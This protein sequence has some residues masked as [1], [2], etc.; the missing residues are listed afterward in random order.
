MKKFTI[1]IP[2]RERCDVLYS[3]IRTAISQNYD[4]LEILISDNYSSDN[5]KDVVHSFNDPRVKYVNTGKRLSMSHNWEFALSH[6]DSGWITFIGDDDGILPGAIEKVSNIIKETKV[7]AVRSNGCTYLWPSLTGKEYGWLSVSTKKGYEIRK[8]DIYY[9]K[10]LKGMLPYTELPVLYNG[11]FVD[12]EVIKKAIGN[13]GY[14]YRSCIPDVYSAIIISEMI[15]EYIYCYEP[16]AINGASKHSN[17][18]SAFHKKGLYDEN[19]TPAKMFINEPN[20][21]LHR[22]IAVIA[23]GLYPLSL[24]AIVYESYLQ[25]RSIISKNIPFVTHM[26]QLKIILLNAGID[27][28]HDVEV[29]GKLFADTHGLEYDKAE[30]YAKVN[31]NLKKINNLIKK[32]LNKLNS[33]ILSSDRLGIIDVYDA[34]IAANNCIINQPNVLLN[35]IKQLIN[36]YIKE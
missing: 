35:L 27:N 4:N 31:R 28:K 3:A 19:E 9:E 8:T 14:F 23:D 16:L 22:D 10:V 12:L 20:I 17:G 25:S 1:V 18:T 11:G 24:E 30:E 26:Q 21:L 13:S 2:T 34:S 33:I 29:W 36:K 7:K 6:V 32:V 15:D 5:T